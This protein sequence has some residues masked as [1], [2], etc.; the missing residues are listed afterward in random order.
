MKED[1]QRKKQRGQ[2]GQ[3]SEPGFFVLHAG[4]LRNL[5]SGVKKH[6]VCGFLAC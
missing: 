1:D 6:S 3:W 4:R 2:Q 5:S